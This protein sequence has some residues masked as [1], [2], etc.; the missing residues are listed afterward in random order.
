M[1][2]ESTLTLTLKVDDQGTVVLDKF[3]K[4]IQKA[5]E[6]VSK[7]SSAMQ[8]VSVAALINI[9]KE[10]VNAANKVYEFTRSIATAGN[11]IQRMSRVFNMSTDDL[12]KWSFAAKM[13]D[14]DIEGFGQGFKFLTRSMSEALQGTGDAYKAFNLLGISLKDTTGKTKD[15][16]TVMME[17]IGALEKYADGVNRDAAMLAIFGRGWMSVKPLIDQGTKTIE[18]NSRKA[19]QLGTILG[20]DLIKAL[21]E[22]EDRYKE[23]EMVWK[24]SKI[25]FWEP[26][27]DV[28]TRLLSRILELKAALREGGIK[29]LWEE[30][31]RREEESL[32]EQRWRYYGGA[33]E[34]TKE[35]VSQYK[36]ETKAKKQLGVIGGP[37]AGPEAKNVLSGWDAVVQKNEELWEIYR[38]NNEQIY[39][40]LDE[41]RNLEI[42]F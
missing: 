42:G 38:A 1:A 21:S 10:A 13:A 30:I 6:D 12:Q 2:K 22:S 4:A 28:F 31:G 34:W 25:S 35:W 5:G 39:L 14:V 29:G 9:G 7:M 17:V 23:W 27:V 18:E 8:V 24:A 32:E 36:P 20:K 41:I 15:Q 19:E 26:M 16:Q 37:Y 11:D 3:T 33:S 40:T